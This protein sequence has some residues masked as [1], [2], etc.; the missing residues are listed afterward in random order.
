M[1]HGANSSPRYSRLT[2]VVFI[3]AAVILGR[4][5]YVQLI[6][7]KYD[8][9]AASN[10]MRP[11]V[12]YPMR[13]EVIDRRGEPL[14][15]SR[16]CY[17]VM[18]VWENLPKIGF[19]SL[20]LISILDIPI[21]KLRKELSKAASAPHSPHLVVGY[22][23][24]DAKLILDEGGFDGFYTRF[25]TAREYPRKVGGNLLGYVNEVGGDDIKRD[26]Y[27]SS[28]DYI[29]IGGIESYYEKELRGE[30]GVSYR[31]RDTRG[32]EKGSYDNGAH[33]QLPE[34]G[35]TIVST[36]D[37]RLQEF[38][39]EL[40]VGK[41]GSVVAIE[42]S[43]GEIL[44][45]VS[46]PT[47]NPDLMVGRQRGNN[48]MEMLHNQRQPQFSRA[49]KENY[50]PGSTFKLVQGLIGLQEGV[51]T[52]SQRYECHQGFHYGV[53]AHARVQ[54]CHVHRNNLNLRE[55]VAHSCNAYFCYVY[56]D[57]I[58][59]RKYGSIK[60]GMSK[61]N[62]YVRSFGF[63][64]KL[65]IDLYGEY[66]GFVPTTEWLDNANGKYWNW[67]TVI[68]CAIGQ[69]EMAA[70]PLQMANL[71]AIVANRGY[72][73]PPHIVRSIEGRDSLDRRFYERN[74]T[75]VDSVH[76]ET[77]IDGMWMGVNKEGTSRKAYLPGL[78]VCGKTGTAQH[79]RYKNRERK[80]RYPDHS[81]FISFAPRNNPK[82]AIAV[83]IEHGGWGA[84]AAVPIASL[85]EELYL[86]DTITRPKMVEEML[87]LKLDYG[88]YDMKQKKYDAEREAEEE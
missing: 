29:G 53:G 6:D 26:P 5:F 39:E 74:Y 81:A 16:V 71:A 75:M 45:M 42:P 77:I 28:G 8:A 35:K 78:D 58:T 80:V 63:G 55:A 23:P 70:T 41:I 17:D 18:V 40:M 30:K 67:G 56:R 31:I 9:L 44:V 60:V 82:I 57:I 43:T 62:E 19:D 76:F 10:I 84:S 87:N 25:R 32:A 15:R 59:N 27:Y 12:E 68:S 47:Y 7:D 20:H 33:D 13:G 36:I 54:R 3:V 24:Q 46:S 11:E 86:T 66:G 34:K 1:R 52:P 38:A 48:Y 51:L 65:G 22:L 61:W 14:I 69:G 49:I 73:Y 85:I 21:E 37:G 79:D 72:Y 88:Y 64:D 4:L 83:Y 50:P 2:I